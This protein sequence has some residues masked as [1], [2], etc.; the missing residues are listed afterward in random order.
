M[1]KIRNERENITTD[2]MHIQRIIKEY[3]EQVML[4]TNRCNA[5]K[6]DNLG[7]MDQFFFLIN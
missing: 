5:H 1:T 4:V 3:Y 7:V 6:F 2:P